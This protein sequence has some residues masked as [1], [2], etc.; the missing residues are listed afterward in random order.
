MCSCSSHY[1]ASE[2]YYCH[3]CSKVNWRNTFSVMIMQKICQDDVG[4]FDSEENPHRGA[5]H[6]MMG[7][8]GA[9][10]NAEYRYLNAATCPDCG[11]GMVRLGGCFSCPACGFSSC[12]L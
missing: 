6:P 5:G 3:S 9:E 8:A 4:A 11:S 10:F 7:S 12:E 2:M 1:K